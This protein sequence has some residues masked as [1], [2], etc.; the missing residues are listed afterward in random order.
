MRG[1]LTNTPHCHGIS[2]HDKCLVR[3]SLERKFN[4]NQSTRGRLENNKGRGLHETLP[5]GFDPV[6]SDPDGNATLQKGEGSASKNEGEGRMYEVTPPPLPP[7]PLPLPRPLPPLSPHHH[8]FSHHAFLLL[9]ILAS[10]SPLP[11]PGRTWTC[12]W[13]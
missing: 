13:T 8:P 7:P 4:Q 5:V 11:P 3:L 9:P 1:V 2:C 6:R 12:Q 10:P